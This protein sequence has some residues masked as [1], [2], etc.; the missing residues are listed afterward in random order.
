M[1]TAAKAG[2]FN[3]KVPFSRSVVSGKVR[4]GASAVVVLVRGDDGEEWV[5]MARDDGSFRFVDLPAGTYS[6][7]VDP[8]GS[9]LDGIRLDGKNQQDVNLA[10]VG[11][12]YTIEAASEETGV[13][14]LRVRVDGNLARWSV[15]IPDRGAA[16]PRPQAAARHWART[17][18][19]L[20][21]SKLGTILLRS[22][23]L[24]MVAAEKLMPKR[25]CMWI[26]AG[27]RSFILSI[28]REALRR[29]LQTR[30]FWGGLSA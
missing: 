7:R 22:N 29:S 30:L 1:E 13:A 28:L 19:N 14:A 18:V 12:G 5:S 9:R 15:P 20:S 26:N 27:F 16:C 21:A 11:W 8:E 17:N 25:A 3:V 23:R 10:V 4:G 2:G 6:V 24:T